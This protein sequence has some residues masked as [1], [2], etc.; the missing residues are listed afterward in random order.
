MSD[1]EK[2]SNDR[3]EDK[4]SIPSEMPILPLRDIVI[5]PYMIVPLFVEREKSLKAIDKTLATK[6]RMIFL[7]AQKDAAKEFPEKDDF[8]DV[9]TVG[10][11]L[12]LLRMP[13]QKTRILVQGI[14][15]G[16]IKNILS[17]EPTYIGKI[18]ADEEEREIETTLEVEALMRNVKANFDKCVNLGKPVSPEIVVFAANT[19]SPGQLADLIAAYVNMSVAESQRI[20]EI[21]DPV[22]RLEAIAKILER[23]VEIL[24]VQKRI[25]EQTKEGMEREQRDY[26]L[27]QQLKTIQNELGE[28][29]EE[30]EEIK[31]LRSKIEKANMP[32]EVKDVAE[33]QLS[34]LKRMH[35]ESSEGGVIRTYLDWLVELPWDVETQDN[36]DIK[37][38]S[39]ILD[40][41]HYDLEEIKERILEFLAVRKLKPDHKG[42]ILCFVGPPGVGKTSLGKSIARALGRKFVRISLGGIRDEAEIRGHRRT[43][44][45]ALPGKIIHGIKQAGTCN[46]VFMMDE[47]D[48]IGTDFRGDPSSAL[49]EVLDPEQNY[50]FRDH[51]LEVPFD[52]SKVMFITT[53]N[54]LEPI[55]PAFLDRME[56]LQLPGYT[57]R[58]KQKI[59]ERYLIPRQI[60][61]NG[62]SRDKVFITEPALKKIINEY[63]REAGL[64]NL[65]REIAVICRKIAKKIAEGEDKRYR[66]TARQLHKF[67]GPPRY[68]DAAGLT[69]EEV[70]K[71]TGLAWTAAGGEVLYVEVSTMKGKGNLTLTG[72]LGDVMKESA[73]AATTYAR[74]IATKL[75]IPEDFYYKTDIHIHIPAGAVPKDGPSAGIT[76]ATALISALAGIPVDRNVAMT[77]EIT[78]RGEILPVGGLKQKVLAAKRRGITSIIVPEGNRKDIE[79][80]P[81]DIKNGLKFFF[82]SKMDD[83]LDKALVKNGSKD[84]C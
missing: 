18:E 31:E 30:T 29:A 6:E 53:A 80:L 65:E 28:S 35:P 38:A 8:Y 48:K 44:V 57:D 49:L 37:E 13:D 68:V 45:G 52:L 46:P 59:A 42:S 69:R 40:E 3:G 67:L 70:G 73:Q 41:D 33:K 10:I 7:T 58:E 62:L 78:V 72:H 19:T 9:G 1:L 63:T 81:K 32:K 17:E 50:S 14:R 75:N 55:Q 82:F 23:E 43:Y 47:V 74:T 2:D 60:E 11:I 22:K 56:V 20:L 77:G 84:Q 39:R 4:I 36:M 51:Y 5:Y 26:Y 64:R 66:I 25:H 83:V 76:L 21:F 15:R 24:E 54:M 34:R 27:R 71:A 16:K 61:E 79:V 12:R